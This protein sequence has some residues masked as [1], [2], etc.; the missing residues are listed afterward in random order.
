MNAIAPSLFPRARRVRATAKMLTREEE[1]A[2]ARAWRD[3]R[4]VDA[5]N[6]LVCAF[7][8]LALAITQRFTGRPAQDDPDMVQHAF[9]GLMRAADGFD[10]DRGVRFSTYAAWWVRAELQDYRMA[11][12]SLV[13]RGRS[14]K[15]RKA[16]FRL[17]PVENSLPERPGESVP[18]RDA[19]VAEKLGVPIGDLHQM[20][21][22]F[23]ARDS[24]LNRTAG[25]A[26]GDGEGGSE[27][28]ALLPDPDCDVE[29]EVGQRRDR[30]AFR[31]AMIRH[32]ARLPARERDILVGNLLCDPPR[33]LQDLGQA[34][35]ISRERV[36][37]LRERALERLRAAIAEDDTPLPS[38]L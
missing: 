30:A 14:A 2:L 34:H 8:P 10:P 13:R 16:F 28:L 27:A 24:S 37:Q 12:W 25:G 11:N 23:A 31:A 17:G 1:S 38:P 20:R 6:R 9:L 35:G 29:R 21:Q 19:R 3:G 32:F 26:Q 7:T 18:E 22:Q 5:R 36:R 15:A 33:T 4:D